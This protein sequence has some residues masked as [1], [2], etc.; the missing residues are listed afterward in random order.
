MDSLR[1][2]LS[3]DCYSQV[4]IAHLG[5]RLFCGGSSTFLFLFK[6]F[7]IGFIKKIIIYQFFSYLGFQN[8]L[9]SFQIISNTKNNPY[10][11]CK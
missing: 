2:S 10:L 11:F 6:V 3:S 5:L 8:L 1:H 9:F 4:P 7:Y